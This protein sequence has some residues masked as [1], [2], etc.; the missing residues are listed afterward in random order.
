MGRNQAGELYT[1]DDSTFLI[2]LL[3]HVFQFLYLGLCKSENISKHANS[4][5]H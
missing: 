1:R 4:K 2:L 3:F 5:I